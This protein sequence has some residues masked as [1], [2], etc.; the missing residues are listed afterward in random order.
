MWRQSFSGGRVKS[1]L[2]TTFIL[3]ILA[4]GIFLNR[5]IIIDQI[6]VWQFQP[7]NEISNL[8]NNAGISGYGDFLYLASQPKLESSEDFNNNCSSVENTTSI[9][10]C[11]NNLKIHIYN[12]TDKK[13]DGVREV[14]AA[15]EML[16]AAYYRM[17]SSEKNRVNTLLEAEY[18][19]LKTDDSFSKRMDF[20][21]RVE[22]GERNNELH[23]IIGTEVSDIS[24]ELENYYKQY[25]SDRSKVVALNNKYISVFQENQTR[26][27]ELL[28][29]FN[30]L[31]DSIA[32]K[33]A[34]YQADYQSLENDIEDFNYKVNSGVISD[35]SQYNSGKSTLKTRTTELNI[36]RASILNDLKK[37]E[38]IRL[39]YNSVASEIEKLNNSLDS[40]LSPV[41]SV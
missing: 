32:S 37:Q 40:T 36:D 25:F 4:A 34:Q 28:A 12:V 5:Q 8:A 13:L 24:P 27:N 21:D 7:T 18:E 19:K 30:A 2:F 35:L 10:G 33:K 22:P 6:N 23:S 1:G 29:E 31:G 17:G 41:P 14:T 26:A 39:E 16:H 9:L 15:H 20:Y 38:S 3:C 11:Y